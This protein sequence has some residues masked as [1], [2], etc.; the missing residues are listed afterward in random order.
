MFCMFC[1]SEEMKKKCFRC[2]E[3]VF[4]NVLAQL[5]VDW[6][7]FRVAHEGEGQDRNCVGRLK[8]K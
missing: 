6:Q 1:V 3:C 4:L 5:G 8:A 7:N 2:E